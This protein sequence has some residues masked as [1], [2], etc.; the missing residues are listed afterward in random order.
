MHENEIL[1]FILG[2]VTLIFMAVVRDELKRLPSANWLIAAF[3]AAW[4]G[5]L[6]TNL[7]HLLWPRFFNRLEHVAYAINAGLLLYWCW[8]ISRRNQGGAHDR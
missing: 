3:M 4:I 2:T 5:W 8:V 1:V 6:T 7:E